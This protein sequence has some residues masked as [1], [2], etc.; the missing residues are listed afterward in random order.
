[1]ADAGGRNAASSKP[2][3]N[4][5]PSVAIA[6]NEWPFNKTHTPEELR[7]MRAVSIAREL[8]E[9]RAAPNKFTCDDCGSR[10]N[11]DLV[12]DGYNTDGDCI[13]DK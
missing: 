7:R 2:N 9:G 13:A 5:A 10:F 6:V 4:Q 11:C 12:F 1:M 3:G 8:H